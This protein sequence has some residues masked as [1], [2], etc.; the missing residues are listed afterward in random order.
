MPTR[1]QFTQSLPAVGTA[2][3]IAG[4]LIFDEGAARADQTAPLA[5]HFHPKGKSRPKN[6]SKVSEWPEQAIELE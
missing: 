2:L 4:N 3:A 5:G 6:S 1:R